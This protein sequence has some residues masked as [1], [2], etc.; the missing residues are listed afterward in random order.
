[1]NNGY[2][3]NSV[4]PG[5]LV[6]KS[7]IDTLTN[8]ITPSVQDIQTNFNSIEEYYIENVLRSNKGKKVKLYA[9][10]PGSKEENNSFFE[11]IIEQS[12]KDYIIVSNPNNGEWYL[13]PMIYLNYVT[14]E[15]RINY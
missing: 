2:Y 15:E 10:I 3:Q 6:N 5:T 14:F 7:N 8:N 12:G 11:G 4:F 13:I 1:M 9:T